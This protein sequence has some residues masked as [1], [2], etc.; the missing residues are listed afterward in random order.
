MVEGHGAEVP[1]GGHAARPAVR[2]GRQADGRAAAEARQAKVNASRSTWWA[3]ASRRSRA[4]SRPKWRPRSRP[5]AERGRPTGDGAPT[6][7]RRGTARSYRR[8]LLKLSGEAL[9]GDDSYG[10]NRHT[11]EQMCAQIVEVTRTRRGAGDRDRRRQHLPRGFHRRG[12][13]GP[14]HRRLHGHAGDGDERAGAAGRAARPGARWRSATT[15]GR[16]ARSCMRSSTMAGVRS[17]ALS[18]RSS[19]VTAHAILSGADL[20]VPVPLHW[21]RQWRRGFNQA[22]ELAVGLGLPVANVLR[23]T[24]ADALP[25]RPVGERQ[26]RQRP[27]RL[28]GPPPLTASTI[29]ASSWWTTSVPTGATMEACARV[30]REGGAREVRTLTAARVATGPPHAHPH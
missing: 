7:T 8:V 6:P 13:H 9:M 12:R 25:D 2:Q 29:S 17:P 27:Q 1:E 20:V 24:A 10:I 5:P 22:Y 4:T 3:R 23:R 19:V 11:I 14:R 30:L 21:L 15:M 28:R 16:S 26:S 18:P